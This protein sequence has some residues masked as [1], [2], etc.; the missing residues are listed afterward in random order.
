MGQKLLDIISI[1]LND[2]IFHVNNDYKKEVKEG[3]EYTDYNLEIIPKVLQKDD[4]PFEG[5]II[6]KVQMFDKDFKE[7]NDPFYLEVQ[8]LGRFSSRNA[9]VHFHKLALQ[10]LNLTLPYVRSYI[11]TITALSTFETVIIPAINVEQL[12]LND[13]DKKEK[14]D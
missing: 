3:E 14:E 9:N 13:T 4:N 6:L 7:N 1:D 11:S 12:L 10:A 2:F 8:V 5:L